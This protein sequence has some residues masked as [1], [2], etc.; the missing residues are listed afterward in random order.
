MPTE[1]KKIFWVKIIFFVIFIAI[2]ILWAMNMKGLWQTRDEVIP[3][4]DNSAWLELKEEVE[5]SI[6]EIR[7]QLNQQ[8]P[9]EP[10][11]GEFSVPTEPSQDS[12]VE[13]NPASEV[14]PVAEPNPALNTGAN[15]P[16]WINCM[17]RIIG[18]G[19]TGDIPSCQVPYGCEGITQI[20]Y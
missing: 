3:P 17:P 19:E 20:A 4:P 16:A 14:A 12:V 8:A 1:N 13:T 2:L 9:T 5:R 11:E 10:G 18:P 6:E 7:N 15:C